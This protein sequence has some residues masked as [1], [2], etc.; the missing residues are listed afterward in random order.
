MKSNQITALVL[1]GCF[2]IGISGCSKKDEAQKAAEETAKSMQ[3]M[4]TGTNA[5]ASATS[6]KTPG[7]AVPAKTLAGFLPSVSG[8]TAK[9]EPETMEMDM[10]G[11]KYSH[12][13]QTYENGDKRIKVSILDYNYITGLS[14]AYSMM[15]NM[16]LET[17]DESMHS[18]KF[19]GNPGWVDWKKNSNQGTVGVVVGDRVYV[20]VEAEHGATLDDLKSVAGAI[21]YSGIASAAK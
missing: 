2:V 13:S 10:N 20:I 1:A 21:N 11:A 18:E 3:Q 16:S 8:Y 19:S 4:A 9:G 17:N 7:V 15:M 6:N 12:A 14:A 5:S